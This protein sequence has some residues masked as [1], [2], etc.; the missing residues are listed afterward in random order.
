MKTEYIAV[1]RVRDRSTSIVSEVLLSREFKDDRTVC[2][3]YVE[4]A[5]GFASVVKLKEAMG[6][7]HTPFND[8]TY[9]VEM[10]IDI[11]GRGMKTELNYTRTERAQDLS[12]D[13]RGNNDVYGRMVDAYA[14]CNILEG[15]LNAALETM[16]LASDLSHISNYKPD[17]CPTCKCD[18]NWS[19]CFC[20]DGA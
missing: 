17:P 4:Q 14:F 1:L 19:G 20:K 9:T 12:Y 15:E 18:R 16:R 10:R 3:R 5:S 13:S 7:F 11:V 6:L 8:F 2:E